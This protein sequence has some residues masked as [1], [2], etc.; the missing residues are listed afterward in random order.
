MNIGLYD[1]DFFKYHQVMFNL[2]IMKMAT[3]FKGKREITVL[4]PTYSPEKYTHFYLRK[5]FYDGTFPSKLNSYDNLHYGGLAFTNGNYVPMLEEIERV[6]PDTFV[7]DKYKH[8]FL[9]GA[10]MHK[11]AYVSLSSNLHL[12]LSLDGKNIWNNFEKQIPHRKTKIIFFH[13]PDLGIVEGAGEVIK[14]LL[15]IYSYSKDKSASLGLKFP[16][17]V[18]SLKDFQKWNEFQFNETFFNIEI[19]KVLDDEEYVDLVEM[20]TKAEA[21]KITYTI[22]DASS[23][24]NDFIMNILPRIFKQTIFCCRHH[25]RILL[26]ISD[27]FPIEQEWRDVVTLFNLYMS[28]A[29]SYTESIPA[30]YVFCKNMRSREGMYRNSVMCKEDARNLFLFVMDRQ[31]ELFKLFY[32]CNQVKLINGGLENVSTRP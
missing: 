14:D 5:D 23:S 26:N 9:E 28:A 6:I 16:L 3:Y 12:R 25:K 15:K 20:T 21:G 7:Y 4:S 30:L 11:N 19:N 18:N 10:K 32:E 2:E 17:R 24:K 8:L 1:I 31:P 27:D 22:A 13:D 29:Q